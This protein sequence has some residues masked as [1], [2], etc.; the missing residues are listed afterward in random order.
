MGESPAP[1]EETGV[2]PPLI[3]EV[4][5]MHYADTFFKKVTKGLPESMNV[6]SNF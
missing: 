1:K 4:I 2:A 3:Q 5:T 6:I